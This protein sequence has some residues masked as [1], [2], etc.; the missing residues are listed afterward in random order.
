MDIETALR[1]LELE[2]P[3]ALVQVHRAYRRMVKRWH[4][5]QFAHQPAIHALAEERLKSINLA[6][7]MVKD[8]INDQTI[9]GIRP[10][11]FQGSSRPTSTFAP[12]PMAQAT[13]Y[14]P[15]QV[16]KR[17]ASTTSS[18]RDRAVPDSAPSGGRPRSTLKKPASSFE[19]I[20]RE[21]GQTK[22][23]SPNCRYSGARPRFGLHPG[24]GSKKGCRVEGS[25]PISPLQPIRPISGIRPI[26]ESE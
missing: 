13:P 11:D 14:R 3:L 20:L 9:T 7:T 17:S 5:D 16:G 2:R 8:H 18:R 6:Y 24:R 4:P 15:Q 10:G 21:A 23:S 22:K 19:R 1:L 26:G 12:K 25:A